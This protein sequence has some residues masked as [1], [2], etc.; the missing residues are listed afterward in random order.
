MIW[1]YQKQ[2]WEIKIKKKESEVS[3]YIYI[4][5]TQSGEMEKMK[6]K[7]INIMVIDFSELMENMTL[8][9]QGKYNIKGRIKWKIIKH[10]C[11]LYLLKLKTFWDRED[12]EINQRERHN[13]KRHYNDRMRGNN[14]KVQP[15]NV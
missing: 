10:S 12:F 13:W 1:K 8:Q 7:E 15:K 4:F 3:I 5:D 9:I 2:K 14:N 11:F 6:S